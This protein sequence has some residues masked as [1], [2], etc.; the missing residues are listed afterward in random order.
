MLSEKKP[1]LAY[2]P[3][4]VNENIF[5]PLDETDPGMIEAREKLF[6]GN[7]IE[8]VMFY[9]S[10]NIRRKMTSDSIMAFVDFVRTLPEE[11]RLKCRYILHTHPVEEA[12]T[13]LPALISDLA[14]DVKHL[15]MIVPELFTPTQLNIL[16][17][18]ADVTIGIASNEGFGIS[19]CESIVAGTPIIVNVTGGLQ[20]QCGFVN[21]DGEYLTHEDYL[22]GDWGSNYDARYTTH[23]KWAFPV[24]PATRSLKGSPLTPYISDDRAN[25]EDVTE[26]IADVYCLGREERKRRGLLGRE[27]AINVA[28]FTAKQMGDSFITNI[29]AVLEQWTPRN[30]Y[31]LV[32]L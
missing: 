3:H 21:E 8:F 31:D 1:F 29:D 16:Y 32:K 27:Y 5:K 6:H 28:Q 26:A 24:F 22:D 19:T 18:I 10:R 12:G 2:I 9:N 14:P 23:G 17:N 7:P 11:D 20:D 4:G 15:I 30:R 13:D 25:R